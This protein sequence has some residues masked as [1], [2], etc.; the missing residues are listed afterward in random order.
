MMLELV[1]AKGLVYAIDMSTNGTF[2]NSKRLPTKD[3]S[4]KVVLWH[5]DELLFQDPNASMEFGY[6]V[7]LELV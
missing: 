2:L 1:P 3:K 5:G 4:A 7:N 6:M